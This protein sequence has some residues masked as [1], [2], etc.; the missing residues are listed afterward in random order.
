MKFGIRLQQQYLPTESDVRSFEHLVK[1][2]IAA[3]KYG[4]NSVW[5]GQ[6]YLSSPY[7]MFQPL[8]TL[9]RIAAVSGNLALGC[10]LILPLHN[11]VDLAERIATMD[12]ISNGKFIFAPALG[13]RD[14]DFEALGIRKRERLLRFV[15]GLTLIRRLWTEESVSF[16][17]K[18]FQVHNATINP[19]PIQ[20]PHPPIWIPSTT[21]KGVI[22]AAELGDAWLIGPHAKLSTIERQM[23]IYKRTLEKLGKHPK[24][25]PLIRELFIAKDDETA[26]KEAIPV[27]AKKYRAYLEWGQ[28]KALPNT[29][30]FDLPFDE[31]KEDRFVIGSID[32]CI[33]EISK[34]K[35]RLGIT[36]FI[37]AIRPGTKQSTVI[38]SIRMLGEN[39][40]PYFTNKGV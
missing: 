14:V 40:I 11:P 21:D 22:R 33:E 23:R 19:K 24:E 6:H 20:K 16:E 7:K 39:V 30:H 29:N 15:E 17:G 8:P 3:K 12:I 2:V 4:F 27:L 36:E 13:Y 10:V 31:L 32:T 1:Q 26:L 28:D 35:K 9:A 25:F 18:H 5:G 37:I 34:Y 38:N